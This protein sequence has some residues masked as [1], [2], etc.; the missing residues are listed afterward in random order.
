MEKYKGIIIRESL[1]DPPILEDIT[2]LSIHTEVGQDNSD[3][4]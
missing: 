2:V 3:G 4:I 1:T